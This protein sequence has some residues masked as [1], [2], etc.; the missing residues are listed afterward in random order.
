MSYSPL[1]VFDH[2]PLMFTKKESTLKPH[3]K[4]SQRLLSY[5]MDFNLNLCLVIQGQMGSGSN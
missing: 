5:S 4:A 2:N 3:L 1:V